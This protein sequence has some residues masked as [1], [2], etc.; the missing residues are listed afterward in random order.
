MSRRMTVA[1]AAV[2]ALPAAAQPLP[3]GPGKQIVQDACLGCHEASRIRASGYTAKD[4]DNVVHMMLN[5]GAPVAADQVGVLTA[6]LAQNFPEKPKPASP[7][8][9]GPAEVVFHEWTVPTP[10]S[11]PHDPLATHD[12]MIWY[13]GHMAGLLGRLDPR[14]GQFTEFRPET[15]N[16]GPHG[17]VE[18]RDGNIWFTE[19][20]AGAIGKL[21][22]RTGQFAEYPMPDPS[23]RDPHTP[24]FDG[25]GMLVFTAQAANRI[26]RLDPATGKVET[27]DLGEGSAP[28]G[29]VVGADG[30]A[31]V[32]DGGAN[33]IA[34]VDPATRAVRRFPLPAESSFANL[35]TAAFD[36]GGILWFTGQDGIY[37]RLDPASASLKTWQAP[38]GAGPYGITATAAGV[39]YASLA[40]SYLGRIDPATGAAAII[41]PPTPR[42]GPRRAW[43]DS[44]GRIWVSEW[45]AGNVAVYDP[46]GKS[47]KTWHLPG[48]HPQAYA[49][50]VDDKDIVWLSDWGANAIVRFDPAGESFTA[51][52]SPRKNAGVRQLL[53][54]PGEVWGAESGTD[55]LVVLTTR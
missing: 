16:T 29:V 23:V 37:G 13:S 36:R 53:G 32:T 18:D 43:A 55:R 21:D 6:Y 35:N 42:A 51:F 38:R 54:R 25:R 41:E 39:Y 46:A 28:H 27:V 15:P 45:N 24:L 33:A 52:A 34:R 4:W 12:G 14:T 8:L 17:L 31:W 5:A 48:P 22:P 19:N 49:V 47:W 2:L 26:G 9:A 3:E 10:G 7:T 50:F 44:K 1:V 30:A 11:R 20:F 40:G